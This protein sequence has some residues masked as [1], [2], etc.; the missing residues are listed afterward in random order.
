VFIDPGFLKTLS[1]REFMNGFAEV[2]KHGIIRSAGLFNTLEKRLPDIMARKPALLE[3][4]VAQ[5]CRIKAAVVAADEREKR[6]RAILN[7]GHT[8][9][10]AIETLTG[11]RK[12]SH[13]QAVMLGMCAAT[14]TAMALNLLKR[15]QGLRILDF[16]GRAGMP[17]LVK[18][19]SEA[20]YGKMFSDKKTRG[21]TLNMVFPVR[22]GAVKI[23]NNPDKAAVLRGI[24]TITQ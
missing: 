12:Y 16:L 24:G 9:G 21:N 17:G 1:R 11:Y 7:F 19:E 18:A 13:G 15:P 4:I 2:I 22:I 23:V 6:L 14:V 20:V 3:A 5:N 8:Y 10:H